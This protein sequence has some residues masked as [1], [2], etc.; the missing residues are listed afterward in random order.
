MVK[1]HADGAV[2]AACASSC[3]DVLPSYHIR[4]ADQP[5]LCSIE[6]LPSAGINEASK[7]IS[8]KK[9]CRLGA[10]QGRNPV[11]ASVLFAQARAVLRQPFCPSEAPVGRE[12]EFETLTQA[13]E[14]F[15]GTGSGSSIYVSG[16]PGTG[17]CCR[18]GHLQKCPVLPSA[19]VF[20]CI[21]DAC[22][23]CAV[24]D[25]PAEA[26]ALSCPAHCKA[27]IVTS[28]AGAC[29]PISAHFTPP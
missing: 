14:D 19:G 22:K 1:R 10:D 2:V 4:A 5:I 8:N 29:K 20:V 12:Q 13:F 24:L 7:L 18:L 21:F 16:L 11:D 6:N 17:V 9:Q 26:P 15:T 23:V 27:W 25:G 3:L 28:A